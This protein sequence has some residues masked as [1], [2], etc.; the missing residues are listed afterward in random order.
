MIPSRLLVEPSANPTR[1]TDYITLLPRFVSPSIYNPLFSIISTLF[2]LTRT[3]QTHFTPL[4]TRLIAQ[5]DVATILALLAI[6]LISLKIL[7]MVYRTIMFWVRMALQLVFWGAVIVVGYWIWSRGPEGFIEDV[8][9]LGGYWMG[10]YERFSG[11]ARAL[12]MQKDSQI[13]QE[14]GRKK[15]RGWR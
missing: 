8:Q 11:E 12:K 14:A 15:G 6:L 1:Q 13:R 5:P 10:E 3:L 7:D 2:G 4:L 9:G